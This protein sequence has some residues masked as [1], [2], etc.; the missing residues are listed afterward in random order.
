MPQSSVIETIASLRDHYPNTPFIA[1]GQT[2]FWDEPV[3]AAWLK[4]LD[5]SWPQAAMIAAVHDTDYFAKTTAL[6]E[7]DATYASLP[8]NDGATRGLWSAA[9]ELST[10]FG[11]E[12]VLTKSL[13]ESCGAPFARLA[14]EYS[15]GRER[16]YDQYT[17]AWGWR[18]IIHTG[19]E[20]PIAHDVPLIEFAPA[21]IDQLEWGFENSLACIA[22]ESRQQSRVHC[23][24]VMGWVRD[25]VANSPQTSTLSDLY[26]HL[27]PLFYQSLLGAPAKRLTIDNSVSLFRFNKATASR[28]RFAILDLFLDE[29]TRALCV[30]AY[31]NAVAGGGMYTLDTFGEG[32]LPFDVVA[33]GRGR[34]TL[35]IDEDGVAIEWRRGCQRLG[36]RKTECNRIGLADLLESEIGA[37]VS[38][39]GKAVSLIDML[40]AEFIL[41]FHE[42]ASGYTPRTTTMNDA[43]RAAGIALDLKPIVRLSYPTWDALADAKV[44]T[45]LQLPSHLARAFGDAAI[46]ATEF[47]TR[48]RGVVTANE[49]LLTSFRSLRKPRALFEFF[50]KFDTASSIWRDLLHEYEECLASL[51]ANASKCAGMKQRTAELRRQIEND[52]ADRD[53]AERA[54][55]NDFR[56]AVQPIRERRSTEHDIVIEGCRD[57][58]REARREIRRLR[59]EC[60]RIERS[61]QAQGYRVR[62]SQ[63]D[64][65]MEAE[66][67]ERIR[68]AFITVHSLSHTQTRPSAWWLSLV[69]PSGAWFNEIASGTQARLERV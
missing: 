35:R 24:V 43:I 27:L 30:D 10:L 63:I 32:A 25:F 57:R 47:S 65:R 3:K 22:P 21:L 60:R 28:L 49:Q 67:L 11:S 52:K 38:I 58:I 41:V 33:A 26:R 44:S 29:S 19:S 8:H 31:N 37:D 7:T 64:A 9:G 61:E 45:P 16:F 12:D 69:D 42:T 48:W 55:G 4:L 2:V 51:S 17:Q 14:G 59:F 40:A 54:K 39:V 34:G 1:L 18:G 36:D 46:S 62:I 20:P 15:G 66:R 5:Q 13:Y 50:A 6:V 56:S 68:D 53:Q 23:Q